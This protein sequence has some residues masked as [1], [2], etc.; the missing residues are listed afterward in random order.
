MTMS[1]WED[2]GVELDYIYSYGLR[3]Q[4]VG[5]QLLLS[6]LELEFR[7][8]NAIANYEPNY[9]NAL[10]EAHPDG[11]RDAKKTYTEILVDKHK[12]PEMIWE[13]L[14]LNPGVA[15]PID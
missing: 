12:T 7:G 15:G 5:T 9:V 4:S 14:Q 8:N 2:A 3:S 11:F 1:D 13:W 10:A 6:E